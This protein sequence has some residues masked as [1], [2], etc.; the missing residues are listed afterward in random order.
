MGANDG[1]VETLHKKFLAIC[2]SYD[3]LLYP[4]GFRDSGLAVVSS[5][6][7]IQA[8]DDAV[9]SVVDRVCLDFG[10]RKAFRG[11]CLNRP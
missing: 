8:K 6:F 4:G 7:S 3:T 5:V 10:C 11:K 9:R 1:T 2:P